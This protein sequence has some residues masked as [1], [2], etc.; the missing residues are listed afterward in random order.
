MKE[1]THY[2]LYKNLLV[3]HLNKLD[4]PSAEDALCLVEIGSVVLNMMIF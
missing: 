2:K 1:K 4:S 3:I